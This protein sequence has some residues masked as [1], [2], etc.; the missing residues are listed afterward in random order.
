MTI[1]RYEIEL[2][3]TTPLLGTAPM[4]EDLYRGF[5]QKK[6]REEHPDADPEEIEDEIA[7]LTLDETVEKGMTGFHRLDSGE[8][9]LYD[10]M[11]KGWAKNVCSMLRRDTTTESYK[12]KAHR[13]V[14]DGLFFPGPRRIPIL[15]PKGAE[16]CALIVTEF[17]RP[18]RA[19]TAQGPRVCLACSEQVAEGAVIRFQ[20]RIR[21]AGITEAMLKEW[22]E[23]G[24]DRGLGQWRNGGYGR[25]TFALKKGV[26]G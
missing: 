17:E 1:R 23:Y 19:E 25:F 8:P 16:G 24:E 12:L 26:D 4:D 3:F 13:K 9:C 14:I 2:T 20:L 18:L 11:I 21:G 22:L 7:D 15:P 10:Y 6:W 5:I